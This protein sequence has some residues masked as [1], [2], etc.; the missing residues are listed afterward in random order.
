MQYSDFETKLALC[1]NKNILLGFSGGADSCALFL[2]LNY[3]REKIPF[4]LTAVHFEHGLRGKDSLCDAK[5]CRNTAQKY[6]VDF[7]QF[8]LNV[9]QNSLKNESVESAARRLRLEKWREITRDM[10][11]FEIHLAHHADDLTENILLRLFR[12]ANVS[13]LC[14]LREFSELNGMFIRRILLQNHKSEIEL[15][16]SEQ[17]FTDYCFDQTNNDCTIGRNYLRNKM[18]CDLKNVFP[19][20]AKGIIQSANACAADADFIE[21]A[22]HNEFKKVQDAEQIPNS[23]WQNLHPALRARVL[24]LY[25]SGKFGYDYIPDKNLLNRFADSLNAYNNNFE[26]KIELDNKYFY[27]RS[28]NLWQISSVEKKL[29]HDIDWDILQESEKVF[30]DYLYQA[31]IINN[32]T[33]EKD[34]FYFNFAAVSLPL[35]ITARREGEIFEKFGGTHTSVK[36]E[37]TNRKIRGT[38]RDRIGILRDKNDNIMLIGDWR[39]TSFAHILMKNAKI[40]QITVEK[41]K[42]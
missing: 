24:R 15:F 4:K 38:E 2:I 19:Y 35:K 8:S 26:H 17:N 5:F 9:P 34:R 37:L 6:G 36:E 18:L 10:E 42:K 30:G 21:T 16:L 31:A 32:F 12:G 29:P 22:A 41:L 13:G 28:N 11:N 40:L 1:K 27:S 7:L 23:F 39:R 14:G 3:W 25:L 20:A 33:N